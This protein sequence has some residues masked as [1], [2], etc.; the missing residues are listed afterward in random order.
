MSYATIVLHLDTHPGLDERIDQAARVARRCESHLVGLASADHSLFGFSVAT[1][2]SG[3]QRLSQAIEQSQASARS[4][5]AQFLERMEMST[6]PVSFGLGIDE[7]DPLTALVR[8]GACCD[9]LVLAQPDPAWP[10][11]AR[12][13]E[14]LEQVVLQSAAPT[15]VLPYAGRHDQ[16]ADKVVVAWDGSHGAARAVAGALPLLQRARSVHLVRCETGADAERG[17]AGADFDLAREWLGRHAV[18]VDALLERS[19]G[20][21]CTALLSRA[22][23]LGAG[24]VVMGAWG[25]PRWA[26][27][28]VGG[29]TRSMLTTMDVPVLMS[30]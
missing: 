3:T 8:R 26:E 7:D 13:R 25:T 9:L 17:V 19:D 16:S 10:G 24:L 29:T 20:N 30:H 4:G 21:V 12:S 28:L 11:H 1:G 6:A 22:A 15:L 27:R 23:A 18:R 14:Q 5:A 2:F